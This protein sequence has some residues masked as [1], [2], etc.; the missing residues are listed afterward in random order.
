MRPLR[1]AFR[2]FCIAAAI[3]VAVKAADAESL[4]FQ[5]SREFMATGSDFSRQHWR[6]ADQL[7]VNADN[8]FH[9]L[10]PDHCQKRGEAELR[11]LA[12]SVALE[13]AFLFLP[14]RCLWIEIGF[15]ETER[16]VR[17]DHQFVK[18]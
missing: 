2:C 18:K 17:L 12:A 7:L 15:N 5:Q 6:L 14:S 9:V 13:E 11:V 4:E 1:V 16:R 10:T 8:S 3:A